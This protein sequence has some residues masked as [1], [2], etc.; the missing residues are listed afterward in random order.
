M[1][2]LTHLVRPLACSLAAVLALQAPLAQGAMIGAD[3]VVADRAPADQAQ[4]EREKVQQFLESATVRDKLKA[5]GVDGLSATK[6]VEAMTQQEVHALAQRIDSL[7]AGGALSDRDVILILLVA[8][9]LI[10]I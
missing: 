4:L 2:T 1:K 8:L 5:F 9:L 6:R 3:A 10:V 7:P